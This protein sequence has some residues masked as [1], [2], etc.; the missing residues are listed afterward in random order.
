M[1]TE[2]IDIVMPF[3]NRL[4][5]LR[6]T[7]DA[8]HMHTVNLPGEMYKY[9]LILAND[10]SNQKTDLDWKFA[11]N[12]CNLYLRSATNRGIGHTMQA[13][14]NKVKTKWAVVLE[15]DCLV[16]KDWLEEILKE[17]YRLM[18]KYPKLGWLGF[19]IL[20]PNSKMVFFYRTMDQKGETIDIPLGDDPFDPQYCELKETTAVSNVCS[21]VRMAA[22][23]D[24]GGTDILLRRQW[25]DADLGLKM[26][27]RG[28]T[29]LASPNVA[30][31]HNAPHE[32][33]MQDR[34][35]H[36]FFKQKWGLI[37]ANI[38]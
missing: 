5:T 37:N 30:F 35:D 31:V 13:L 8:F 4:E 15:S 17:R 28:W 10:G 36:A 6:T 14:M 38:N 9:R 27:R 21:L 24:C 26:T 25:V 18:E 33:E 16:H 12:A 20:A 2:E 7:L 3:H 22:W 34:K 29:V 32:P 11:K 23:K 19:K 1:P